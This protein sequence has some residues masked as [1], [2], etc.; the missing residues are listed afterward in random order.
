VKRECQIIGTILI[1]RT[2]KFESRLN[3]RLLV[4]YPSVNSRTLVK[5]PIPKQSI[6]PMPTRAPASGIFLEQ[7]SAFIHD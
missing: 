5:A 2:P 3:C 6:L 1:L 4:S 7:R